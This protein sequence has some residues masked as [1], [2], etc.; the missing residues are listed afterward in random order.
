ML[1]VLSIAAPLAFVSDSALQK[2][3]QNHGEQAY[4][5]GLALNRLVVQLRDEDVNV[6]LREVNRFFNQFPYASDMDRW[7]VED[8]WQTPLEFLG[9][10]AGDCEDYV[11]SKYF[12][13]RHLGIDDDKL[14]LTYV[15][16]KDVNE[17]HMVLGYYETQRSVP[18]ILDNYNPR[19][20]PANERN[21]LQPVYSFNAQS[22]FTARAAGLGQRLPSDRVRNSRWDGLL[23]D[24][25]ENKR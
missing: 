21:D 17:A 10:H 23:Q 2:L 7:G 16:A 9:T 18:L 19:I 8:Y 13:L 11:I 6:Q 1:L 24:M 3:R 25:K 4:Q 15:R 14:F 5:R 22:L 12:V 20:L